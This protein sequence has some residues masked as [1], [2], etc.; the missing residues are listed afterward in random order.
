MTA[1]TRAPLVG[2]PLGRRFAALTGASPVPT[3]LAGPDLRP[4]LVN[5][6]LCALLGRPAGELLER[7]WEAAVHPDD[8][9]SLAEAAADVH[10]G[11][12][13]ERQVRLVRADGVVRVA[14]LRFAPVHTPDTGPGFVGTVEDVTDRLALAAELAR[15]ARPIPL[16]EELPA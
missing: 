14:V 13:V 16:Q 5:E 7:G 12:D 15:R 9:C 3:L 10:D 2:S 4:A 11:G 6:A 8:L 1:A